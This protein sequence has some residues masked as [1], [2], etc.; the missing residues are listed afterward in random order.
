[1]RVGITKSEFDR[2]LHYRDKLDEMMLIIEQNQLD[3]VQQLRIEVQ[4]KL[5]VLKDEMRAEGKSQSGISSYVGEALCRI[6]V[7]TNTHPLSSGWHS[8][9]YSARA[10]IVFAIHE[11]QSQIEKK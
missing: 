4:E 11:L 8:D 10:D 2:L 3:F 9:L 1:M 7:A 5:K 6:R